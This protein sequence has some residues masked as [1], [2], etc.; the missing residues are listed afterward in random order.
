[1]VTGISQ[2]EYAKSNIRRQVIL[3]IISDEKMKHELR[4][5]G[6]KI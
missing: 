4:L 3:N 1:M 6:V 5:H 2:E